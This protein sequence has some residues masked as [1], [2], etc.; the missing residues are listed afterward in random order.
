MRIQTDMEVV[1]IKVKVLIMTQ[2]VQAPA[3]V[4]SLQSQVTQCC[5]KHLFL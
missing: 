4:D 5:I 3:S 1:L 2:N